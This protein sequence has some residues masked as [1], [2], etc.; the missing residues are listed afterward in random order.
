MNRFFFLGRS[1][2]FYVIVIIF[3]ARPLSPR[4]IIVRAV[5]ILL[6][7]CVYVSIYL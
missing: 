6:H 7:G 1:E 2:Y 5:C 3:L 4:L